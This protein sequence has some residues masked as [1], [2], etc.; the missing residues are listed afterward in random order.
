ELLERA[1]FSFPALIHP[2]ATVESS[3]KVG[4]GVQVFAN[5]YIGSEAFLHPRCM[6][7]TNAVVSHDC[8]I[9]AYTHIA[10]GAL[11][12]GKVHV[13]RRT[14]VGM[15]VTTAIG[16]RIGDDVRIGNGANLLAD[17]PDKTIIQAGRFWTGI[18]G[19]A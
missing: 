7:N 12:A 15:G 10:P 13:G 9:G 3:A 14:L 1:G 4:E 6:I 5:T 8:I 17:V 2:H 16:V 11:L 18:A 19:T